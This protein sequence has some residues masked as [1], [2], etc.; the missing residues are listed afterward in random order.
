MSTLNQLLRKK[1]KKQ[2]FHWS[3]ALKGN[4]QVRGR[5]SRSYICTPRKPNSALRKVGKVVLINGKRITAKVPGSGAMPQKYA[6]V[7]VRGK[8]HKDTPGVGY[9]LVRGALECLPLF[10]KTRRRSVYG[11]PNPNKSG[12][13]G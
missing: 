9:S 12:L 4:P 2:N 10:N 8:G 13:T 3:P 5:F 11:A 6:I 1:K 7:L